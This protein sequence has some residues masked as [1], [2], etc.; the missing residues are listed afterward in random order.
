MAAEIPREARV[1]A[2]Y[3]NEHGIMVRTVPTVQAT[4]LSDIE[5]ALIRRSVTWA[6]RGL[7]CGLAESTRGGNVAGWFCLM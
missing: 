6:R 1:A 5:L 2:S 3:Y 7:F 4:M